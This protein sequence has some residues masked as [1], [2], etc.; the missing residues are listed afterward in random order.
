M[1]KL[2]I[3]AIALFLLFFFQHTVL[4][5]NGLQKITGSIYAYTDAK[6]ASA[7]NS[8][9]A[10]AGIIIGQDYIVAVDSLMS[11]RE[12]QR[13]IKDIRKISKKPIKFLINTHYHLDHSLGNSE[14]AK[15]GAIIIAQENDKEN[16][17]KNGAGMLEYAKKNGLSDKDLQGT[18][19]VYPTLT[20]KERVTLYLG[21]NK[22]EV[23]YPGPSHTSGSV[24]VYVPQEKVLFTGDI[25]FTNFHPFMG[26]A[27][28]PG[29][30]KVLDQVMAMDV[31]K[32]IPGHG[33]VSG[34]KDVADLQAY[35]LVFDRQAKELTAK[36][37][38][39]KVLVPEMK[40]AL[41]QRAQLDALIGRNLQMKY[42]PQGSKPQPKGK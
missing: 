2:L 15:L 42:L 9:G 22:V 32:I 35:L 38:D 31:A 20:F 17:E 34:K 26:N 7:K 11:A 29:W 3:P 5:E 13:F 25:L 21:N 39:L 24:L 41:P 30:I 23:I 6:T 10:N 37:Q 14:F 4:A 28:I 36:S 8:F 16:M 27:D 40:K 12:A 33:P 1:K 18:K 19:V